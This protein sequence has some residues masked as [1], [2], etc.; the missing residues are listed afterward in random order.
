MNDGGMSIAS[1][2]AET[3]FTSLAGAGKFKQRE[4]EADSH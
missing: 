4:S 2:K 1:G 3:T